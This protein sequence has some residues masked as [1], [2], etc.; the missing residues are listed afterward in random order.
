MSD[1][2]KDG[3]SRYVLQNGPHKECRVPQAVVVHEA[4]RTM[5]VENGEQIGHMTGSTS[6]KVWAD[7]KPHHVTLIGGVSSVSN[8][9]ETFPYVCFEV[10]DVP[11]DDPNFL[12]PIPAKVIESLQGGWVGD[13]HSRF[14]DD[15]DKLTRCLEMYKK[16]LEWSA[17]DQTGTRP[18]FSKLGHELVPIT[19]RKLKSLRSIPTPAKRGEKSSSKKRKQQESE[20]GSDATEFTQ[21]E[22][23]TVRL[24][25]ESSVGIFTRDGVVYATIF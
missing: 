3:L 11:S 1:S 23:K 21:V 17:E 7:L 18:D 2:G 8:K 5:K 9:E 25:A 22:A 16:V 19:G 13:Y 6:V 4:K 12:R 20:S 10:P 14:S 24:G 15:N